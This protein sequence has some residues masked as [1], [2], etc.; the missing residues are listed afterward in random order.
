VT[1]PA[2]R[3]LSLALLLVCALTL[4]PSAEAETTVAV[5]QAPTAVN[6]F[7][8]RVVWSSLDP[9]S[10]KFSLKLLRD[11]R[12]RQLGARTRTAPFDVDL[13]PDAHGR[14]VAVYS[15][16]RTD[17]LAGFSGTGSL[18]AYEQG[19]GCHIYRYRFDTGR[20]RRL[21]IPGASGTSDYRPTIWGPTV[22][23]ARV[24]AHRRGVRGAY[25]YLYSVRLPSG[26][27][28][29]LPGG[30]RGT[31]LARHEGGP[32]PVSLDL[33]GDQLA[34]AWLAVLD[35]CPFQT[36]DDY[37]AGLTELWVGRLGAR[38]RLVDHGCQGTDGAVSRPGETVGA[39]DVGFDGGE[40]WYVQRR[41]G[42][43]RFRGYAP[44]GR[45]AESYP[46]SF[47]GL[48]FAVHRRAAYFTRFRGACCDAVDVVRDGQLL[49]R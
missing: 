33:R 35:R 46:L 22:V 48:G 10:G 20:E 14:V 15:R 3:L 24:F 5:E 32:G 39:H 23:F 49:R 41:V 27:P 37:G 25:P 8:S 38:P 31:Y 28:R 1:P 2:R 6:A 21:K 43:S 11:G 47:A 34:F 4:P 9:A 12:V 26:A 7:R 19:R 40:L 36:E 13:G 17:P 45:S 18:A 44:V 42:G 30:T 16:C 29:R